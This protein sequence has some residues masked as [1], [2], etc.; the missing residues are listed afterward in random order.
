MLNKA[1]LVKFI[2]TIKPFPVI[3]FSNTAANE[4]FEYVAGGESREGAAE[5]KADATHGGS[6]SNG[7]PV[8]LLEW[9]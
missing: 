4:G 9:R 5:G 6:G 8:L 3:A 1:V 2:F 7:Q